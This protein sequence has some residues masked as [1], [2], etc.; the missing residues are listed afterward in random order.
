MFHLQSGKL[1]ADVSTL[2]GLARLNSGL[3]LSFEMIAG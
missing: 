3:E 1:R 2:V